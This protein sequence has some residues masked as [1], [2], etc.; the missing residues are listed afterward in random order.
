MRPAPARYSKSSHSRYGQSVDRKWCEETYDYK[1]NPNQPRVSAGNPGGGQWTSVGAGVVGVPGRNDPRILSDAEPDP[2]QAG[3]QYA[4]NRPRTSGSVVI[5]GQ[6]VELSP[7]QAA[8]LAEIQGRAESAIARVKELDRNWRPEPS[9]YSTAE[10]LIRAYRSDAEQAQARIS[11][12]GRW[13]IGPGPFACES[14]PA[15]GPNRDFTVAERDWALRSFEQNGCHTCGTFIAGTSSGNPVL[16][17]QPPSALN[18]FG[19]PQR[20][21]TQCLNCSHVQGGVAGQL[22]R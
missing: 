11:E 1:F 8:R 15:R 7:G 14:I 5:N 22:K 17:H 3:A 20:L 16:D 12:L 13:G 4:Q 18:F 10:G 6:Q 2:I 19:R 21:F 9:A